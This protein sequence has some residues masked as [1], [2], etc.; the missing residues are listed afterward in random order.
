MKTAAR[1]LFVAL[2]V[3]LAYQG[4]RAQSLT[5]SRGQNASPA[6]EGWEENPDGSFSAERVETPVEMRVFQVGVSFA[7]R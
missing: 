5:Y 3:F 4:T 1:V 2:T 7:I 6:Y